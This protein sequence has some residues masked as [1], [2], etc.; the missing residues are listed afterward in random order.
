MNKAKSW[1]PEPICPNPILK[2]EIRLLD[3]DFIID[4]FFFGF[5]FNN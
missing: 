4:F 5:L 3:S 2:D 1:N